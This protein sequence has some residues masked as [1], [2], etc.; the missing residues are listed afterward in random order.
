ML[1]PKVYLGLELVSLLQEMGCR[2]LGGLTYAS[3]VRYVK[4][5]TN[6]AQ[7]ATAI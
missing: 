2:G 1:W 6:A 5:A 4:V 7:L 3:F